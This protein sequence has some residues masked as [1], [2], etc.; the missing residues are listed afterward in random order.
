MPST[1]DGLS[2]VSTGCYPG[3]RASAFSSSS[4][5]SGF[6]SAAASGVGAAAGTSSQSLAASASAPAASSRLTMEQV[7]QNL[8]EHYD[9]QQ[10]PLV[11]R[12]GASDGDTV[13]LIL[14]ARDG[15][16]VRQMPSKEAQRMAAALTQLSDAG[17]LVN[18]QV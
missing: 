1:I 8:Q 12:L 14:D 2:S 6:G 16:L 13:V 9:S 11:F 17:K 10:P 15:T 3:D 18:E 4:I 7:V 5:S